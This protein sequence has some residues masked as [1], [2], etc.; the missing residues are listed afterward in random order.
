MSDETTPPPPQERYQTLR[1]MRDILPEDA[2]Y[3]RQIEA[4]FLKVAGRHGFGELRTPVLEPTE[5]F[6]RSV[7]ESSDIV[8]KELYTFNDR[9]DNSISLRPEGTA[10]AARAYLEHG[11][12]SLPQP[13]KLA[14]VSNM[15]R[16]E[17]PQAGRF[18]EHEQFGLEVFGSADP[19]IDAEVILTAWQVY[20]ELGATDLTVQINSIGESTSRQKIRQAI[21]DTLTPVANQLSEDARRQLTQN[22]LRILDSK[23]P[24]T[25]AHLDKLPPLIDALTDEDRAH[26]FMVLEYLDQVGIPYELNSRLVRGLDYYTRT[27]F[28]IWGPEGGAASLGGGGRYDGLLQTVGGPPTPGFGMGAGVDR[29]VALLKERQPNVTH[30][31]KVFIIQLGEHAKKLSF[32]LLDNLTA[33]GISVTSALGKDSIR[34]QLKLADKVGAPLALIIGQKE[35]L[36][37]SIIIRDMSSGMQ[38]TTPLESAVAHLQR[39]LPSVAVSKRPRRLPD[40]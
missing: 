31:P 38:E 39:R 23:D 8:H 9:S 30:P 17:R 12:S 33:A 7:G 25:Q 19:A 21:T 32:G 13:V 36:D 34:S 26:F 28:E 10:A 37:G 4:T 14:Y 24:A 5:L 40:S 18:R 16:Y 3:Y 27:V 29:L 20:R 15:Y 35:A 1:G 11:M 2:A 22:P 6:V